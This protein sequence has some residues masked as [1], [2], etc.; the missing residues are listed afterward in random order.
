MIIAAG[1]RTHSSLSLRINQKF[2]F[3]GANKQPAALLKKYDG[4]KQIL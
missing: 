4:L 1:S 3:L 2:G